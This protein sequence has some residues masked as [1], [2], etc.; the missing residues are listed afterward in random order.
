NDSLSAVAVDGV[1]AGQV[2][3][4]FAAETGVGDHYYRDGNALAFVF[5]EGAAAD[6]YVDYGSGKLT[7]FPAVISHVTGI[8]AQ[9]KTYD[10]TTAALLDTS[11]ADYTGMIAG[12][13]L[14]V[15]AATGHFASK[16]AGDN[17]VVN[18]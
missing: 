16:D 3:L 5:S 9:D 18:I 8:L 14:I 12:D 10:G 1:G 2:S 15:A 11:G 17:I 13:S 7:V 4:E 6:Y